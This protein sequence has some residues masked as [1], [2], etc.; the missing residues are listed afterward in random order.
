MQVWDTTAVVT[1]GAVAGTSDVS[2]FTFDAPVLSAAVFSRTVTAARGATSYNNDRCF[3]NV[4]VSG[5]K[6]VDVRGSSFGVLHDATPSVSIFGNMVSTSWTSATT[7]Q[8]ISVPDLHSPWFMID[9]PE[10][11]RSYSSILSNNAAL[12]AQSRLGKNKAW[13]ANTNA[14]GQWMK[15]DLGSTLPVVGIATLGRYNAAQ[16]VKSYKVQT[17]TDDVTFSDV[18]G[19]AVFAG[20]TAWNVKVENTFSAVN[21]RYVKILPQ[22]WQ[23]WL[24]MRAAVLVSSYQGHA[25]IGECEVMHAWLQDDHAVM[26]VMSMSACRSSQGGCYCD[27]ECCG[28]HRGAGVQLRW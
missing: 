8:G 27:C 24:T 1:V 19:G 17:S 11:Q 13:L 3:T 14:V 16:F 9:P 6:Y 23:T 18:N 21:T 20:N 7:V 22:T 10:A 12:Y 26:L 2:L 28:W 5:A 15:I 4:P 25:S